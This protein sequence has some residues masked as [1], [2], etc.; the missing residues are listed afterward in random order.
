[1]HPP[2]LPSPGDR[3]QPLSVAPPPLPFVPPVLS[4]PVPGWPVGVGI[5]AIVLAGYGLLTQLTGLLMVKPMSAILRQV[6][7]GNLLG[8]KASHFIQL[9]AI[10][11][12]S[13]GLLLAVGGFKLFRR[14]PSARWLLLTWAVLRIV[15][16]GLIAPMSYDYMTSLTTTMATIPRR[17]THPT[18]P[19][20]PVSPAG[21]APAASPSTGTP[22]TGTPAP[23][24]PVSPAFPPVP[25]KGMAMLSM[26]MGIG[27]G[28]L[29]PL[30]TLVWF[31]LR[32]VRMLMASWSGAGAESIPPPV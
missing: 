32:K 2:P 24:G 15:F 19:G 27:M 26:V 1:M 20:G 23:P 10:G 31:N 6:G 8:D 4:P 22:S 3:F 29:L 11:L 21:P 30:L 14:R 7:A 5:T 28:S 17:V 12:S 25:V 18:I 9:N 13:L 16:S